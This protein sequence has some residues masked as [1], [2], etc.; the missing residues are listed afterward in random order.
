MSVAASALVPAYKGAGVIGERLNAIQ[1]QTFRNIEVIVA[2]E[3]SND[4]T[5][6]IA[7]AFAERDGRIRVVSNDSNLG[8]VCNSARCIELARGEWLRFI[9]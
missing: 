6:E 4:G 9:F 5:L 8:V 7:R 1:G 3:G 2:D